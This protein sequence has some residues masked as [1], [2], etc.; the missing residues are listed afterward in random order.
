VGAVSLAG[1]A[2]VV[3]VTYLIVRTF[4]AVP[5]TW[6]AMSRGSVRLHIDPR[7][8]S[9]DESVVKLQR[10]ATEVA[11]Y[12]PHFEVP[13]PP[14][15]VEYR[16]VLGF[17]PYA[18]VPGYAPEDEMTFFES[19]RRQEGHFTYFELTPNQTLSEEPMLTDLTVIQR[20]SA[21]PTDVVVRQALA[22][23]P[24]Y[25][26]KMSA[27]VPPSVP[28]VGDIPPAPSIPEPWLE[29][30]AWHGPLKFLNRFLAIGTRKRGS[31]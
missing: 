25:P 11:S 29:Y 2:A 16:S 24:E 3:V 7:L 12:V 18:K 28:T 22:A 8:G 9:E 31:P 19:K 14:A 6:I 23:L 10:M 4:I 1:L 20:P 5:L 15:K 26:A 21:D 30:P 27:F 13:P 17:L